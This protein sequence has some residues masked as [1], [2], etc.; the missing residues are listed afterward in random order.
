MWI[1]SPR[2]YHVRRCRCIFPRRSF[3]NWNCQFHIQLVLN[4]ELMFYLATNQNQSIGSFLVGEKF[5]RNFSVEANTT[6]SGEIRT[7]HVDA[8]SHNEHS[9]DTYLLY[10]KTSSKSKSSS[11]FTSLQFH[12]LSDN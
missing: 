11:S 7:R 9:Y 5:T 10:T 1:I 6:A 8:T 4:P 3:S 12:F 2:V